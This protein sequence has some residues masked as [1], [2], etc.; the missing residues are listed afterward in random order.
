MWPDDRLTKL[1]GCAH[2]I[3]LAPMAGP[4]TVELAIGVADAGGLG[5]FP[6]AL[7]KPDD[8]RAAVRV[9]RE[10]A[11]HPLNLNFFAHEQ[12]NASEAALERWRSVLSPYYSEFGI[13][14]FPPSL[15]GGRQPFDESACGLVEELRP[16]IVSFH[17]GLPQPKLIERVQRSGAKI[18]GNATT[19][20]EARYL[21]ERGCSAIIAQGLEAGGHRG[22]FLSDEIGTQIG[23]LAL[24]PQVAD[25]VAIPVIAAGGIADERAI[26]A[27]FAL[28]AA[29]VQIGSAFLLCPEAKLSAAHKAA[30]MAAEDDSTQLTNL[31]TGRPARGVMNRL[32]RDL[33]AVS[34]FAPPFPFAA[35][36]LAPLRAKAEAAGLGDFSPLWAG[37]AAP[38]SAEMPAAEL[39]RK[40]AKGALAVLSPRRE[41]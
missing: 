9:F 6:C 20:R 14:I 13:E 36:A 5:S 4:G 17:F 34:S 3:V 25:A 26:A 29:G 18:I 15:S 7:V 28:G 41:K 10:H 38:L 12:G 32:M 16:E 1:F 2:P 21:E 27:A 37:Q 19:V 11:G 23:S 8:I 35:D 22:M 39:T 24:I 33:G 31:F 30:L 40:L